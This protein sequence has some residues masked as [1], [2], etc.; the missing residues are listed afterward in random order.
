[1]KNGINLLKPKIKKLSSKTWK[2]KAWKVFSLYIR[3]KAVKEA[4]QPQTGMG[5]CYTC[6]SYKD[7]K[8]LDAGHWLQGRHNSVMFDE[9]NVHPQCTA[10]NRFKHGNLIEYTM[11][12]QKEYGMAVCEDL[13]ALNNESKPMKTSDYQEIYKEYTDK[14]KNI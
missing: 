14:L 10:C 3:L 7:V 11:Q 8:D 4:G 13:R 2:S 12:M 5:R 6:G 9:R 1:M